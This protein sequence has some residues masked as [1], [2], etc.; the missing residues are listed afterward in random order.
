M[1]VRVRERDGYGDGETSIVADAIVIKFGIFETS[2]IFIRIS[3]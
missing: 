1:A 3:V 2:Y